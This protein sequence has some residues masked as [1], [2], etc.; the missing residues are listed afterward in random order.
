MSAE[1]SISIFVTFS[2]ALI[3]LMPRL[4]GTFSDNKIVNLII[5][6]CFYVLGFYLMV[7]NS[8]IF[9]EMATTAGYTTAIIF[10]YMWL[11]G[12]GG[13]L[14][15]FVTGIK[16]LFDITDLWKKIVSEKRGFD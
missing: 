13:Y 1:L 7:M 12:W 15:M 16:T 5:T 4:Y 3:F 9:A 2:T 14:L 8:A 10:R 11:F 6:R